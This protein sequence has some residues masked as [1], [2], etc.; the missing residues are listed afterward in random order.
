[1]TQN[2]H[3]MLSLQHKCKDISQDELL[4]MAN[5]VD[6]DIGALLFYSFMQRASF[7][8]IEAHEARRGEIVPVSRRV[9]YR[10]RKQYI[11][12]IVQRLAVAGRA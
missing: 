11:N 6:P 7:E 1:M 3:Y 8:T 4:S 12:D 9:F 5:N 10:R 2:S